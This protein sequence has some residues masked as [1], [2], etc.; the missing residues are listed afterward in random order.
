[1]IHSTNRG[2]SRSE[3]RVSVEDVS[4]PIPLLGAWRPSMPFVGVVV[5]AESL[6]S[7]EGLVVGVAQRRSLAASSVRLVP[8]WA[9]FRSLVLLP[10]PLPLPRESLAV[11]VGQRSIVDP[12]P[13]AG[14]ADDST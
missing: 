6:E 11:A 3:A 12:G 5:S 13:F 10:L 8:S 7:L 4:P 14:L 1:M 2:E 9:L